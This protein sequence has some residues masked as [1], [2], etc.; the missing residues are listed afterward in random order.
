MI[1]AVG[2]IY[3]QI[4]RR[5]E[6]RE[7]MRATQARAREQPG[8][9]YFAFTETLDEPGHFVVVQQWRDQRTLDAHYASEVFADYQSQ[10]G[11]LLVRS[12]ELRIHEVRASARPVSPAALD[13]SH[14]D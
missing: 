10:I 2:D 14:D 12:S 11:P 3:A 9:E 8:C 13:I 4:L 5:E 6:V 1:V 7:L